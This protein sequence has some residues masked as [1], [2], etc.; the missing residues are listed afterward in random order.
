M[1]ISLPKFQVPMACTSSTVQ[2]EAMTRTNG[3]KECGNPSKIIK[4]KI[5][6]IRL[7]KNMFLRKAI[8]IHR[9]AAIQLQTQT[10]DTRKNYFTERKKLL[11]QQGIIS[12][13]QKKSGRR[14]S[15]KS[16]RKSDSA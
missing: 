3:K 4:Q 14:Q 8:R 1:I 6:K 7:I 13:R 15:K 9:E 10:Q 5:L 16:S 2:M 11:I 12:S